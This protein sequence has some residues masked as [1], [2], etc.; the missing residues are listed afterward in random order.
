MKKLIIFLVTEIRNLI[1]SIF[2]SARSAY[3]SAPPDM[4][5]GARRVLALALLIVIASIS[6][7]FGKTHYEQKKL[8]EEQR[9]GPLVKTAA[10]VVSPADRTVKILGEAKPYASVTLYAKVSG[11][12][13]DVKVDKGDIVKKNQL[14]AVIESPETDK[15]Y[16]AAQ[17]DAKNKTAIAQ[18]VNKLLAR[19]LV[20]QQEADQADAD[21][22]IA[23]AHLETQAVL[24]SYED[25]RAPFDGTITAR[26][27]DPGALM[28]NAMNS[29]TSALPVVAISQVNQLRVYVY[30]DQRDASYVA[31]G[32][33]AE[34]SLTE[35]PDL[36]L[37][38]TVARVSGELDEKTRML[39]T[40][41]DLENDKG[42]IVPGSLVQVALHLNTPPGVMVPTEALVL[43]ETKTMVPV[44]GPDQT[45]RYSEV[46]V[47]DD[48]GKTVKI[49]SGLKEGE[50]V[51]LNLGNTLP[52]GSKVRPQTEPKPAGTPAPQPIVAPTGAPVNAPTAEVQPQEEHK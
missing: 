8:E 29:Q 46:K 25:L 47:M 5:K 1:M 12:L 37:T 45:I 11:Y 44:V 15:A 6:W 17:S 35:N 22:D 39:L 27:A 3:Q 50:V 30:L 18:R 28:Q 26:F 24:K 7:N 31:K 40:E 13:K 34:V 43:K 14:L 16:N 42:Q 19:N 51:A 52:E 49:Q 33:S 21:S 36:V 48:D 23:K 32:Q 20:S 41:I 9:L 2:H 10:A 38:G 4:Q